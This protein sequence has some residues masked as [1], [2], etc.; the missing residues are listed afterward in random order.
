[1]RG[2]VDPNSS[3]Q[4]VRNALLVDSFAPGTWSLDSLEPRLQTVEQ[5][6]EMIE[7]WTPLTYSRITHGTLER[8]AL[9]KLAARA[10]LEDLLSDSRLSPNFR[11]DLGILTR[12]LLEFH[13]YYPP[14]FAEAFCKACRPGE[15]SSSLA[16]MSIS[17]YN[18]LCDPVCE[19]EMLA[20]HKGEFPWRA[21]NLEVARSIVPEHKN[22]SG[23]IPKRIAFDGLLRTR[24]LELAND[25]PV[26]V[27]A[28]DVTIERLGSVVKNFRAIRL[29]ERARA[30]SAISDFWSLAARVKQEIDQRPKTLFL[31]EAGPLPT[32]LMNGDLCGYPDNEAIMID[33]GRAL[34]LLDGNVLGTERWVLAEGLVRNTWRKHSHPSSCWAT[35]HFNP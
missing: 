3:P 31:M 7:R 21:H 8:V 34:P 10:P 30:A 26:C 32:V 1:V 23:A 27:V 35:S 33:F 12:R 22:C 29:P 11:K 14:H 25:L 20:R 13:A 19:A 4:G 5:L 15:T 2:M 16:F 9:G 6:L 24:F 18:G 28:N 17:T